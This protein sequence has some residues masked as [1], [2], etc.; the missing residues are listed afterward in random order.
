MIVRARVVVTMDGACVKNGA[1]A[2]SG[3]RIVDVGKFPEVSARYSGQKIIDLGERV[4][5]PGLYQRAL[6]S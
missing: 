2:V 5:M 6:P 3:D 1:V 4:L